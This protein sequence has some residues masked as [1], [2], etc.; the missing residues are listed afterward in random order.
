[1]SVRYEVVRLLVRLGVALGL[2]LGLAAVA[3]LVHGGG[4]RRSLELCCYFVGALM[5]VLAAA[6]NSPGRGYGL[7]AESAMAGSSTWRTVLGHP[8]NP[9]TNTLAPAVPFVFAAV[10]LILLGVA[11]A[12]VG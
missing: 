10:V 9:P 4:Y 6:G 1:M 12:Y 2:A 5:F 3:A 8:A 7:D 11:L